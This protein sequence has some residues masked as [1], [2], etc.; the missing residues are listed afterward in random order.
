M[1]KPSVSGTIL[2]VLG[3]I[4]SFGSLLW[5]LS[6][7]AHSWQILA[8][9][10]LSSAVVCSLGMLCWGVSVALF[11]RWRNGSPRTCYQAGSLSFLLPTAFLMLLNGSRASATPVSTLVLLPYN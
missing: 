8:G 11:A 1:K 7:Q 3:V 9:L 2:I 10:G 6:F 4:V 5:L